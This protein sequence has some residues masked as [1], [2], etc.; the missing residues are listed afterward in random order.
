MEVSTATTITDPVSS[1]ANPIT[2]TTTTLDLPTLVRTTLPYPG[3]KYADQALP[4]WCKCLVFFFIVTRTNGPSRGIIVSP[5]VTLSL[6]AI[7]LPYLA[8]I[9]FYGNRV[10]AEHEAELAAVTQSRVNDIIAEATAE[11]LEDLVA[12]EEGRAVSIDGSSTSA[13]TVGSRSSE[14][15]PTE[16]LLPS[17]AQSNR[18]GNEGDLLYE[19]EYESDES[20]GIELRPIVRPPRREEEDPDAITEIL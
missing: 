20:E 11:A 14:E 8:F 19:D 17:R 9:W 6:W 18:T 1:A 5:V 15:S 7:V 12:A 3:A 16:G 2:A 10:Q 4:G 13:F